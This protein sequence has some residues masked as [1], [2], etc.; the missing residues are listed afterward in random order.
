L[1]KQIKPKEQKAIQQAQA[2]LAQN[3]VAAAKDILVQ[4]ANKNKPGEQLRY[5][6]SMCMA[7]LGE[8]NEARNTALL[9]IKQNPNNIEYYK[10][11]GSIYHDLHEYNQ[12]ITAFENALKIN[13]NDFQTLSNIASSLKEAHKQDEAMSYFKKSLT[14]QSNQPDALTNY[15][16]LLQ[17][18]LQLDEAIRLHQ[19]ALQLAP[20]HML[21]M[22]NLAYTLQEK[23]DNDAAIQ[24]YNKLLQSAPNHIKALC[25]ISYIYNKITQYDKALAHL[26]HAL[27]VEPENEY[28]HLG[29]G[30]THKKLDNTDAAIAS[31]EEAIRI[32]P[33]N[34]TAH[35]YL[36]IMSGDGSMSSSPDKYVQ[37]LFDG[38]AETFD[39][40]LV[41]KLKYDIPSLIDD[42]VK[43]HIDASQRYNILDLGCG[44]GL[45]GT[46]LKDISEHMVGIDLS[47]KMLKKAGDR[48]IYDELIT[49]SIDQYFEKHDFQPHII[50][51]ADVFVYIG[52]ISGI[53]KDVA[54]ALH[55]EGIFV[56]STE[57]TQEDNEFIL[58]DSGRFAHNETY[59]NALADANHL[60]LID[61]QKTIV[62]YEDNK[63]IHGRVYL[64]KK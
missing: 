31:F 33:N 64:L 11:L 55:K 15:G 32:N 51:S 7:I 44:T 61:N 22:Y 26:Q 23:G 59:I 8:L 6:L 53:F 57:D 37:E 28:V 41:E 4:Y 24:M 21:A 25:D 36:A 39:D 27:Q 38:Y 9:L 30:F 5:L 40:Q 19:K 54:K 56:F 48:N 49:T 20:N 1:I 14:I 17:E 2:L 45:V 47:S 60:S 42:M 50:V 3:N 35:Y 10:L 34:E 12:A 62:R 18:N 58:K 52:D 29:L 43:K 16:L 13:N 63:P 46:Y